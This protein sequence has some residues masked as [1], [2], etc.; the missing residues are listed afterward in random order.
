MNKVSI[1]RLFG[2]M[3][4][5]GWSKSQIFKVIDELYRL[6]PDELKMMVNG[7]ADIVSELQYVM[8]RK[9][10]S[11]R[12]GRSKTNYYRENTEPAMESYEPYASEGYMD[13]P[14]ILDV[15]EKIHEYLVVELGLS[16][17]EVVDVIAAEIYR[18]NKGEVPPLSKKSLKNWVA[19][20]MGYYSPGEILHVVA[21]IRSKYLKSQA[22]GWSLRND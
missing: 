17:H 3:V 14:I 19:R 5:A 16:S 15:Y 1:E 9:I 13:S 20:L 21:N 6:H 8:E 4:M 2:L 10:S 7:A 18:V 22:I 11:N 12:M